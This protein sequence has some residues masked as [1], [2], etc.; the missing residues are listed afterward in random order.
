MMLTPPFHPIPRSETDS[1]LAKLLE[2]GYEPQH[3][4]VRS[5]RICNSLPSLQSS[6]IT[7]S[8]DTIAAMSAQD[9]VPTLDAVVERLLN[10]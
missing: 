8:Q 9:S 3:V 5:S 6:N 1:L 7:L 4:S 2:M 10:P